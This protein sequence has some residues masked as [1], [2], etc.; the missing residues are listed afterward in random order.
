MDTIVGDSNPPKLSSVHPPEDSVEIVSF[1]AYRTPTQSGQPTGE[2]EAMG[3]WLSEQS[4]GFSPDPL[5]VA[6][7]GAAGARVLFNQ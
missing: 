7:V 3:S 6:W 1:M 5:T 2:V 4:M